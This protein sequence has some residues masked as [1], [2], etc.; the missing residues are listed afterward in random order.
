M[1]GELFALAASGGFV[2]LLEVLW[3]LVLGRELFLSAG[4]RGQY[5]LTAL[6]SLSALTVCVGLSLRP[7]LERRSMRFVH[8]AALA[9]AAGVA[10]FALTS[11]RR[12][13]DVWF[14]PVLVLALALLVGA[15]AYAL[16]T[17]VAR[18]RKQAPAARLRIALV[19]VPVVLLVLAADHRVLPRGYP[20][21]HW[22]LASSAL[23]F[24]ALMGLTLPPVRVAPRLERGLLLTVTAGVLVAPWLIVRL[25]AQP[26]TSYVVERVAPWSQKLLRVAARW[27]STARHPVVS[28]KH[29]FVE[30]AAE[31]ASGIDLRDRDILLITVDA[32]RA[33]TLGAYG[34]N[35][36][37][38]ELDELAPQ[39]VVF[40]R[41]YTPA[42]HTSYALSS[43][44]TAKFIK[45]VFEMPGSPSDH[46]TLPD[47][48]R[49]YG[50]R[51]SAFYPPAIFFVDGARFD[52]LRERG[53]GFEYRKEMYATAA[54][55]VQQLTEYLREAEPGHPLFVWTHLFEPHEPYDPP[56]GL[57]SDDSARGRYDGEVRAADRA[58]GELVRVFRRERPSATVIVSADHGEEFGEHG[59]QFHGSSLF[60]EQIRVPLLWCS[61]EALARQVDVPVELTDIGTTLLGAARVP[62][63]ARM[64]GDDLGTVLAGDVL[65]G[66]KYAF[67]SIEDRHMVSDGK[68]KLICAVH[69]PHCRLFDLHRDSGESRD[70][71]LENGADVA[72]LRAA[73]DAFL[74][75]IPRV[76]AIAVA[77]GSSWPEPLARARLN[78]PGAGPDVVPLLSDN[79]VHVRRAAARVLGELHVDVALPALDRLRQFDPDPEVRSESAISSLL[80]GETAALAD[81]VALLAHE[82]GVEGLSLSRRAALAL[83][84]H[85]EVSA[86]PVLVAL[87]TDE[88]ADE[89]HRLRAIDAL[90]KLRAE[91]AVEVLIG[92]LEGVRFRIA[93]AEALAKIGD[94][95]AIAALSSQLRKEPYPPARA[96]EA[97]ALVQL[98]ARR[99][100][101]IV[102]HLLGME[103][104]VPLGVQVLVDMGALDA[105]SAR[106]A[107]VTDRRVRRGDWACND[108]GCRPGAGASISLQQ[109]PFRRGAVRVTWL[110]AGK[111][112]DAITVGQQRY[113]LKSGLDQLSFTR[114]SIAQA[115]TFELSTEGDVH[116]VAV[117]VTPVTAELPPPPPE[118]WQ[119]EEA[120]VPPDALAPQ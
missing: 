37:T 30:P 94:E 53:F 80:L 61:P 45:P 68:Y 34:G 56:E 4:E 103:T 65:S 5:A 109:T 85:G 26:N 77:E 16:L 102:T 71:R 89:L 74:S 117:A 54:Q 108:R 66:P 24:A 35:G 96:A 111:A 95:R 86:L 32:L 112:G 67:A 69:D 6:C 31:L 107:L 119:A 25:Q 75:S 83:A 3:A 105:P 15:C 70:I 59:G 2:A 91:Q 50:Y 99:V 49:R 76:E 58:I 90:G 115:R 100:V 84:Q 14:R 110:L 20:A 98:K 42:P 44:L 8:G 23:V 1:R 104:G 40:R 13:H 52:V 97:R 101:P 57:E 63:E 12:L 116:V 27:S 62:R 81:V 92:L 64:R 47:L 38:P 9:L 18:A 10:A 51:T 33:D 28:P 11:G 73:L 21:L 48:L 106:G 114:A 113:V 60:D 72:R 17:L 118:P 79:R 19:F 46:P 120:Q 29:D 7:G 93:A 55:R 41:A 78:A 88:S 22:A 36:L 82:Q 43:L 39:C 87:A